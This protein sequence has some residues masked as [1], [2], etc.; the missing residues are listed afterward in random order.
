MTSLIVIDNMWLVR[1]KGLINVRPTNRIR[2]IRENHHHKWNVTSGVSV[3]VPRD[4][5]IGRWELTVFTH[6]TFQLPSSRL[7]QWTTERPSHS[8]L[9]SSSPPSNVRTGGRVTHLHL[10]LDAVVRGSWVEVST[11][12]PPE[13]KCLESTSVRHFRF[14]GEYL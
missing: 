14:C 2:L 13:G 3:Y 10:C 1:K 4:T 5:N 6:F 11:F 9:Q 7:L 12:G 8:I